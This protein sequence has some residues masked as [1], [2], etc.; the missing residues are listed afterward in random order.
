MRKAKI[1]PV[2]KE[3]AKLKRD[4]CEKAGVVD[5][6]V[7]LKPKTK[8]KKLDMDRVLALADSDSDDEPVPVARRTRG[9]PKGSKKKKSGVYPVVLTC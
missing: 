9:R 2:G 3:L 8:R 1:R 4:K 6:E 7:T 5:S